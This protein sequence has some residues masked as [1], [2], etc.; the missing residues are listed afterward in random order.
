MKWNN[1]VLL[2][3]SDGNGGEETTTGLHLGCRSGA[4]LG[5]QVH[6]DIYAFVHVV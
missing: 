2:V 4:G 3:R 5:R 6:L 1:E